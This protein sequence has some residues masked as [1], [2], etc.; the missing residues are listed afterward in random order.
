MLDEPEKPK[1]SKTE[2]RPMPT[3]FIYIIFAFALR[4]ITYSRFTKIKTGQS[5]PFGLTCF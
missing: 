3:F 1:R 5:F 2:S 4:T